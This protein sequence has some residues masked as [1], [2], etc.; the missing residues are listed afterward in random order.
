MCLP[1]AE[2]FVTKEARDI[3]FCSRIGI[4]I[5]TSIGEYERGGFV[6]LGMWPLD[7]KGEGF[8]SGGLGDF[9]CQLERF[10]PLH[11]AKHRVRHRWAAVVVFVAVGR[12]GG[13]LDL[14]AS[15]LDHGQMRRGY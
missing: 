10:E 1:V 4:P 7:T 5:E 11:R 14:T 13:E 12:V 15:G 6:R 2:V 8:G 9:S 3:V